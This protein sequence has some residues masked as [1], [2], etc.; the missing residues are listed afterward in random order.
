MR[1][2][3]A[4]GLLTS[5]AAYAGN[6]ELELGTEVRALRSPSANALTADSLG[7][8]TLGY[9]HAL[10][11]DTI[12]DLGLWATATYGWASVTGTMFQ[13]LSTELDTLSLTVGARGRYSLRR[14]AVAQAA[15]DLGTARAAVAIRDDADHSASDH[16]WGG[17]VKVAAGLEIFA[18]ATHRFSLGVRM[19]FGYV[20]AS[21]IGLTAT[22][23][24]RNDGTLQLEMSAA[25]LG[26][27]DLSGPTFAMSV[28]SQF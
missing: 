26:R 11:I 6:H 10:A 14:W 9:A 17:T 23:D 20:A 27:L 5:T 25:S 7:G 8:G 22:P 21:R 3:L 19:D 4:L 12:P 2:L 16:G 1:A 24:S 18:V 15:L 13:K 28:L